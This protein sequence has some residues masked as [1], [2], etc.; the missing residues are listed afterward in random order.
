MKKS[1]YNNGVQGNTSTPEDNWTDMY[2]IFEELCDSVPKKMEAAI[3]RFSKGNSQ[4]SSTLGLSE[5]MTIADALET[6]SDVLL[7]NAPSLDSDMCDDERQAIFTL[8]KK[9]SK[10][11]I[12]LRNIAIKELTKARKEYLETIA[13]GYPSVFGPSNYAE[14]NAVYEKLL[15]NMGA[16]W[17]SVQDVLIKDFH[18]SND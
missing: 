8:L 14:A 18:I 4:W 17:T 11:S 12:R 10:V 13:Y 1:F 3:R 15:T 16:F 5:A 2:D 9:V 6:P 7:A